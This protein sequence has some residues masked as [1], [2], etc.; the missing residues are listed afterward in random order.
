MLKPGNLLFIDEFTFAVFN[1]MSLLHKLF[2]IKNN[3]LLYYADTCTT[4]NRQGRIDASHLDRV[5]NGTQVHCMS[6]QVE[7]IML[8]S[9][10]PSDRF[11][12]SPNILFQ[13]KFQRVA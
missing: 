12:L 7:R 1:W 8:N 6:L 4:I 13:L 11:C 9:C 10:T 5:D 3:V 2:S